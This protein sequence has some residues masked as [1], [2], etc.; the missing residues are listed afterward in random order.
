MVG[1]KLVGKTFM[2]WKLIERTWGFISYQK[3]DT[4]RHV[5]NLKPEDQKSTD[6]GCTSIPYQRQILNPYQ[7]ARYQ[8]TGSVYL[9][10]DQISADAV[11]IPYQRV[12]YKPAVGAPPTIGPAMRPEPAD[13][14]PIP[15]P[16]RYQQTGGV[17]PTEGPN[18][19]SLLGYLLPR[20]SY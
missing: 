19:S 2:R 13:R 8:Q 10:E 12:S 6:S 1:L 4:S 14:W 7:R 18:T 9:P 17:S 15:Y 5:V 3:T 20:T 11:Y 16:T